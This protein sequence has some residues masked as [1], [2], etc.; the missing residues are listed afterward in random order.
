MHPTVATDGGEHD[1]AAGEDLWLRG[2][3]DEVREAR[4]FA[5]PHPALHEQAVVYLAARTSTAL[6]APGFRRPSRYFQGFSTSS[7]WTSEPTARVQPS[8]DRATQ[9]RT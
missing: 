8:R 1:P 9:G 4:P 6:R 2:A 7:A 5:C 3:L